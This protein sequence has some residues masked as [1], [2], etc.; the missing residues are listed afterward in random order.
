MGTS[1]GVRV[2]RR[3]FPER[4]PGQGWP[5]KGERD[6]VAGHL[7]ELLAAQCETE[8]VFA[9]TGLDRECVGSSSRLEDDPALPGSSSSF[10]GVRPRSSPSTTMRAAGGSVMNFT[11]TLPTGA[12]GAAAGAA[13]AGTAAFGDGAGDGAASACRGTGCGRRGR[14]HR[15]RRGGGRGRRPGG[16]GSGRGSGG[17]R[18]GRGRSDD[19]GPP[20]GATATGVTESVTGASAAGEVTTGAS[21]T[22]ALATSHHTPPTP[23]IRT[24]NRA[25]V[26]RAA[27]TP[28]P[29]IIRRPWRRRRRGRCAGERAPG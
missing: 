10:D 23:P 4:V 9:G 18:G 20:T 21:A 28:P 26:A 27:T 8:P 3:G 1:G 15:R 2:H 14:R 6:L 13:G 12:A 24:N 17:R 22:G 16:R 11:S 19:L 29:S 7:R 25:T 5:R